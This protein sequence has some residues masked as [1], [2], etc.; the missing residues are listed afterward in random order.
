MT[1]DTQTL[2]YIYFVVLAIAVAVLVYT[3]RKEG[4][5]I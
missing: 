4:H 3:G 2:I 1:F 5:L